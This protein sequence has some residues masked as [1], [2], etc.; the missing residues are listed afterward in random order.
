MKV[1]YVVVSYILGDYNGR[2]YV[3]L[4]PSKNTQNPKTKIGSK[5]TKNIHNS[6]QYLKP[7]SKQTH[8]TIHCHPFSPK[9]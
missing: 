3:S 7:K 2:Y 8:P 9:P 5:K 4:P 1:D 6:K